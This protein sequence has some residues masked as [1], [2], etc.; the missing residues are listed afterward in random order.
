[1]DVQSFGVLGIDPRGH[2][3]G[4]LED[5]LVDES[6]RLSEALLQLKELCLLNI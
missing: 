5:D 2:L 6:S 4:V 3:C 1:M